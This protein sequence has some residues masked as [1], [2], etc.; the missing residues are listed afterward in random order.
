MQVGNAVPPPMAREI[1]YEIKKCLVWKVK[2][3][4]EDEKWRKTKEKTEASEEQ[5][6]EAKK[7]EGDCVEIMSDSE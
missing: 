7:G 2:Q 5:K 6:Q 1:G 3:E 4:K